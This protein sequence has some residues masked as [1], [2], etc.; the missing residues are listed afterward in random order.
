MRLYYP[1][2]SQPASRRWFWAILL[3]LSLLRL[4]F[5]SH[6]GLGVDESHYV[7]FAR[8]LAWGYMDHPPMVAFLGA[9]TA[10]LP[11]SPLTARIGAIACG[12]L[13]VSLLRLLILALYR[14]ERVALAALV[15]LL[16]LPY[17]Q[18]LMVALLPDAPLALFWCCSLLFFWKAIQDDRSLW[19]LLTGISFGGCLLSKYHGILLPACLFLYLLFSPQHRSRLLTFKPWLAVVTGALVFLPNILWNARHDW[20]S[21]RFQLSR[22]GGEHISIDRVFEVLGAQ[23]GVW[24]PLMVLL[25][26]AALAKLLL[27]PRSE[28]DRFLF[29]TSAPVFVFFYVIGMSKSILP[30]W[31]AVGWWTGSV[32]VAVV[33][34]RI[35]SEN[36]ERAGKWLI[37]I[38]SATS[39]GLAM[40]ILVYVG[41]SFPVI[42]PLYGLL[43]KGAS[44]LH[45]V[46]PSVKVPPA[47][48]SEQDITNE[49]FGWDQAGAEITR[50]LQSMPRPEKTFIVSDRFYTLSQLA[51]YL[52]NNAVTITLRNQLD[53][54]RVW[55]DYLS[56][57]GWDALYIEDNRFSSDLES[58][59]TLFARKESEPILVRGMRG[60][61]AVRHLRVYRMYG[62][63]GTLLP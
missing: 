2:L 48:R 55:H 3:L 1:H 13:A 57:A 7:L 30:H 27:R 31:V 41:L 39:L 18:L 17:Q 22:S 34:A 37:F 23:L 10:Y 59:G 35:L 61:Q 50:L 14:D 60:N 44:A 54:H 8:H 6:V 63:K 33:V 28:A 24:S 42:E 62:Y 36:Q 21:Y 56:L 11:D 9:L 58:Y 12:I 19:W 32:A 4:V 38:R 25:L 20:I 53:Q 16:V 52:P 15:V 51:V 40:S 43:Q 46:L 5:A 26:W 45:A 49:L 29:W 47:L